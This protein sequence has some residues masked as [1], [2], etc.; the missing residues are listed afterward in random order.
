[1]NYKYA[2]LGVVLA[3]GLQ[4]VMAAKTV[5]EIIEVGYEVE[6]LNITLDESLNGKVFFSK[7]SCL[8]TPDTLVMANNTP[9]AIAEVNKRKGKFATVICDQTSGKVLRILW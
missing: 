7:G 3:S 4:T 2:L 1:M 8:I 6:S 9:V 5:P